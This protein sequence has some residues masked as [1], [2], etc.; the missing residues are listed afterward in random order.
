MQED[1]SLTDGI[2][3]LQE[4]A[5]D[6][7]HAVQNKR[8][9][10]IVGNIVSASSTMV[11]VC[12][13]TNTRSFPITGFIGATHLCEWTK[14]T[15]KATPEF[16]DVMSVHPMQCQEFR[17][18][19]IKAQIQMEIYL[20]TQKYADF[21]LK[22]QKAPKKN[23]VCNTA[24]GKHNLILVPSTMKITTSESSLRVETHIDDVRFYLGGWT[25]AGYTSTLFM[26]PYVM[27]DVE[28]NMKLFM[29]NGIKNPSIKIPCMHNTKAL[30]AGDSLVL[31]P[32]P[33]AMHKAM[34]SSKAEAE[35]ASKKKAKDKAKA[36]AEAEPASKKKAMHAPKA[37]AEPAS[38][39]NAKRQKV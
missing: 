24:F 28:P 7:G 35:P 18:A 38:K 29:H 9:A 36:K 6:V 16:V 25:Q 10:D 33:K 17:Y 30:R 32:E 5:F 15:P 4:H 21:D 34:P 39:K 12:I 31:Q 14:F 22:V 3:L 1:G 8:D 26:V 20:L 37:E 27:Q 19:Y 13:G 11:Q 2:Q 23:V